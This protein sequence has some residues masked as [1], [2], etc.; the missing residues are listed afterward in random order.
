MVVNEK[1]LGKEWLGRII[2]ESFIADLKSLPEVDVAGEKGEYHTFVYQGPNFKNPVR[3]SKGEK[4]YNDGYWFLDLLVS[5]N[6]FLVLGFN[7]KR[8]H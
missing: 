1:Y 8:I 3:F 4:V 7:M 2:N 6:I 5:Y